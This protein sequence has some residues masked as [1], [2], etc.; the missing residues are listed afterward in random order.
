MRATSE[1]SV[2]RQTCEPCLC[3]SRESRLDE[4]IAVRAWLGYDGRG[5]NGTEK[6]HTWARISISIVILASA[7]T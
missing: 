1:R 7:E 4:P 6:G 3:Q 2:T 5:L